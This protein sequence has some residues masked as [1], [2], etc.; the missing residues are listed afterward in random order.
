[1][2]SEAH[3]FIEDIKSFTKDSIAW[4]LNE[5]EQ[6]SNKIV[7]TIDILLQDTKRVSQM[8][9]ESLKAV[10]SLKSTLAQS[11]L[12]ANN[13]DA[14]D[15]RSGRPVLDLITS[16]RAMVK[17]HNEIQN[18]INPILEALQFQDRMTQNL[19]NCLKMINSWLNYREQ[20]FA[21]GKFDATTEQQFANELYKIT[22]MP[23]ERA[24]IKAVYPKSEQPPEAMATN[25]EFF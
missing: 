15:A 1:M 4:C 7:Q 10:E 14:N 17:E 11:F 6:A 25:V 19:D 20:V 22:T 16:L 8:S 24:V 21:S 13:L 3:L 12:P 18:I 23:E 5:S 2:K 9:D